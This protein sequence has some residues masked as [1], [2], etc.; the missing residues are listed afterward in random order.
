MAGCTPL[1]ER[2]TTTTAIEVTTTTTWTEDAFRDVV[3]YCQA[4]GDFATCASF[5]L[6]LRDDA[7]CTVEAV[8]R[9]IDEVGGIDN[10]DR[11]SVRFEEVITE[12]DGDGECDL[13]E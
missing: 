1:T 8:Y 5:I 9:V 11:R 10:E 6:N 7:R 4:T 2:L 13:P 12:L 3:A